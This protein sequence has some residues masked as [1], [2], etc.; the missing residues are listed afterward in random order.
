MLDSFK[1]LVGKKAKDDPQIE[2]YKSLLEKNPKNVNIRLKLGDLYAKMGDQK[3]AINE[4]TIAAV[5]YADEGYLVKAIAVNKIIVRLDPA[6]QEALDRLSDLYFQ[7]GLSADPL[8]QSYRE[9][10]QQQEQPAEGAQPAEAQAEIPVIEPDEADLAL[11]T[12]TRI[13]RAE[14][15]LKQVP[16][17][18][19]L[20]EETQRWLKR[21]LTIRH[22][23]EGEVILQRESQ[24][25]AL[26][27]VVDGQVKLLTKDKEGQDTVLDIL[28]P[29]T[30]FGE[31]SLFKP[32]RQT[33]AETAEDDPTVIAEIACTILEIAHAD[34]AALAKKEPD[35]SE[36]LL[37]EYYK[38]RAS[39]MTL[40]R[41]LLFSHL[42]PLERRKIAERLAPVNVKK[43]SA[44]ITEGEMGD[45]MYLIKT[46]EVGI[47]T[48]LV[49][50]EGGGSIIKTDRDRLHLAT[51]KDGDFFGEQALI[52]KEPRSATV[53][54]LTD[55]QLL[56]F[57]I[58]DLAAVVKHY[59]RVGTLLKKYH[60]KRI[61]DTMESLKSIW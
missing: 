18:A 25:N 43:G 2:T 1:H 59:P 11:D 4:Y 24:Q 10:K 40:A 34:L 15:Y 41:V 19:T 14:S 39:D 17:L 21:H 8:V 51:L 50:E 35:F 20:S 3:S 56:K 22:F 28:D 13:R 31:L 47:Y 52:T 45:C 46:G 54:A 58:H 37:T 61:A 55:V 16:L 26:F 32:I 44:I 9:A 33:Q 48:T 42:A 29:G 7:R 49:E 36:T 30:F 38:R 5:Q 60:Q 12:D 23:A 53:M 6:R 57:S 27:I